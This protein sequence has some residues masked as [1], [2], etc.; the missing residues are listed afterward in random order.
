[1]SKWALAINT[2]PVNSFTTLY[3]PKYCQFS[4]YYI[5]L[6]L[7]VLLHSFPFMLNTFV[8]Q[9]PTSVCSSECPVGFAKKYA[10]SHKCCFNCKICPNGSYV[11][12]TGTLLMRN[13]KIKC[14][15]EATIIHQVSHPDFKVNF[16]DVMFTLNCTHQLK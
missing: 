4:I 2:N 5:Y 1:M 11:N 15:L 8:L 7:P 10:G 14:F 6:W 13:K 3:R 16:K 12:I 9:A